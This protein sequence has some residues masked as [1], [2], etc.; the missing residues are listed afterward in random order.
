MALTINPTAS[1]ISVQATGSAMPG[2]VLQPGTVVNAQV[3]AAAENLVQI[4]IAGLTIDVLSEIPLYLGQ[5]LKLAVSQPD[6]STIRLAVVGQGT[7]GAGAT[8]DASSLASS[9]QI[10]AAAT[11]AVI[12]P[13]PSDPLT[14]LERIA[15]SVA[16]ESA[17]AQQ[18]SLGPLFADLS[19]V[20]ATPGL[21]PALQ[22]AIVQVLAQQTSLDPNLTGA[23]VQ[24]AFQK[25]GLFLEAS[26]TAGP[27]PLA[28]TPDLKAALIVLRQTLAA[29]L[30]TPEEQATA[31]AI[32][33]PSPGEA[34]SAPV[35]KTTTSPMLASSQSPEISA[36]ELLLP[37]PR[38]APASAAP[39]TAAPASAAP[40]NAAP[41]SAAPANA[42]P[43][44]AAP[45]NAAPANAAPANAAPANAA[46]ANAAALVST[47]KLLSSGALLD[48]GPKSVTSGAPLNLW[49]EAL[50]E[51]P[52]AADKVSIATVTLQDGRSADAIVRT[53]TPPPPFRGALPSAQ[54]VAAPSIT[55]DAPLATTLRHLL[56]DTDAALARQTLLQVASLPD[57]TDHTGSRVDPSQPRWNFEVPF[58]TPQGTAMAQF[59]ISRDGAGSEIDPAK[60]VW[61]VRF[62]LDIEPAGPVH[63]LI[64]Y[65]GER[66]SVRMWAERPQTAAQ[67]RAGAA[68]LSQALSKAEL[69]PGDIVIREGTPPIMKPA[70]AGHFLDR[71]L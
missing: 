7:A 26:L 35:V 17:A 49:Q 61:R 71:A 51:I 8:V 31:T 54:A 22:Q 44:S 67:L 1:V 50:Q 52:R 68:E 70:K 60:R 33:A 28:G 21:P 32:V 38:A 57:R 48:L 36:H 16:S 43:A 45:A 20:A 66:T 46:A 14:P 9:A 65:S 2:V 53:N 41:A 42:A 69:S 5:N 64:A 55:Q 40:A 25:S 59:E 4:A 19:T 58:A 18:E 24:T 10:A 34:R 11:S 63:A 15:V 62:S 29:S 39:A 13:A 47:S 30:A 23:D 56:G 27:P 3:V 37:Q 12:A 6:S